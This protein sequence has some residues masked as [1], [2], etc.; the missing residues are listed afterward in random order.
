MSS[1]NTENILNK[2]DL[3]VEKFL[4]DLKTK[5]KSDV[6]EVSANSDINVEILKEK[7]YEKL[8]FIRIY[9]RPK[10]GETDFKEPFIVKE[11]DSG[12]RMSAL[13]IDVL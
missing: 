5:I 2:I 10:G 3:A 9:M 8:K 1:V 12:R 7:I 13:G 4:K 6:I 11:G